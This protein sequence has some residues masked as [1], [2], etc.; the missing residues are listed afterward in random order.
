MKLVEFIDNELSLFEGNLFIQLLKKKSLNNPYKS[1]SPDITFAPMVLF[2]KPK[3]YNADKGQ[4][5]LKIRTQ[6]SEEQNNP[7]SDRI[8]IET[9]AKFIFT[10]EDGISKK[11]LFEEIMRKADELTCQHYFN[12]ISELKV[13][14]KSLNKEFA[15]M[16]HDCKYHILK[17]DTKYRPMPVLN[18][19]EFFQIN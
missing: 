14:L 2:G 10:F 5:I 18:Y 13:K 3:L 4:Y 15:K 7:N 11:D 16:A 19:E 12:Y 9:S 17:L 6:M 8:I 1:L